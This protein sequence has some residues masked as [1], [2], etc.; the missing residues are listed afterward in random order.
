MIGHIWVDFWHVKV[1][2]V[3]NLFQN[4]VT[5]IK[6]G[7]KRG[8]GLTYRPNTKYIKFKYLKTN[9]FNA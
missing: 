4:G 8:T 3:D 9:P 7:P 2:E 1:E 5:I 6:D